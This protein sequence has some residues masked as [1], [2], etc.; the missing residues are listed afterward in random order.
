MC[1]MTASGGTR[2]SAA[3]A[4]RKRYARRYRCGAPNV[5]T[6]QL[7][8]STSALPR[9]Q[10]TTTS[11]TRRASAAI[12]AR[13]APRF[14]SLGSTTWVMNTILLTSE[15]VG[16][17]EGES[18]GAA[19]VRQRRRV[20]GE[21]L[22]DEANRARRR[23]ESRREIRSLL[24]R[25]HEGDR[26]VGVDGSHP[27]PELTS[28]A[29]LANDRGREAVPERVRHDDVAEARVHAR[30]IGVPPVEVR[31]VADDVMAVERPRAEHDVVAGEPAVRAAAKPFRSHPDAQRGNVLPAEL[32]DEDRSRHRIRES[33]RPL[34]AAGGGLLL[35]VQL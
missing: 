16:I 8:G 3:I 25:V 7:P 32:P 1:A 23:N 4:V 26:D 20:V 28:G 11:S 22:A 34:R 27:A 19:V 33:E 18:P 10:R 15:E 5:R 2:S 13:V 14:G 35:V 30:R 29:R 21:T 24:T 9:S 31:V 12:F 17:A 6:R